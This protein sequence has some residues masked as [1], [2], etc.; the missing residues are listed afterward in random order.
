MAPSLNGITWNHSRGYLP[1]VAT[2]QRF[3]ER[4]P[5]VTIDWQKRSLQ[6]FAD[7]PIE[8]LAERFDLIVIDHPFAGYA[9]AR[10]TLV[11]LDEYLPAVYLADQAANSVGP[12]HASYNYGGHQWALAIDAASPV[13]SWRPGLLA[14]YEAGIPRTWEDLLALA[15][16]GLVAL[17]A[18]PIDS[19]MSFCM[20]CLALGE[21]PFLCAEEVVG[22]KTGVAAL[23][24]MRELV[25]LC[26]PACLERN[27]IQTY[28]AM[29]GGDDIVY[30]PFAY[31]YVNYAR[32]EYAEKPLVFGGMVTLAGKR[33]RSTLGG[34]GL[35]ISVHC[36]DLDLALAYAQ[37]VASPES[38]T[39][40]YAIAGGQPG[41]RR[42]WLD[43]EV[44]RICQGYFRDTLPA[45]DEAWLRP[46]YD[47]YIPFQD[48]AGRFVHT[49]FRNGGDSA[50]VL[51]QLNR[52]YRESR[53]DDE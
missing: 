38:Q 32:P 31:G 17:P 47:G 33:L 43:P 15:R 27:P 14:H 16:R 34:T 50:A 8:R 49:Y 35:A 6:A 7:E 22:R 4:N 11:P 51:A 20:L 5:G 45:L 30:C 18:I 53:T 48:H 46:R 29:V 9:A 52:L 23:E 37:F 3:M 41:H 26:A 24:A 1:L 42:A 28:E 12:S 25:T 19:L 10:P 39:G 44:N 21:E 36:R 40:L 2:A 13:S